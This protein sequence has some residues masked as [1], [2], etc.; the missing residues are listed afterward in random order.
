M[1]TQMC[2]IGNDDSN[3]ATLSEH[4]TIDDHDTGKQT[5]ICYMPIPHEEARAS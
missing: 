2:E 5:G 4:I 1:H 3:I